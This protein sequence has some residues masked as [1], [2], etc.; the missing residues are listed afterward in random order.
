[1]ALIGR[2]A[3]GAAVGTALCTAIAQTLEAGAATPRTVPA[4]Q[5]LVEELSA[6]ARRARG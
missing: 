1:V 3:D 5:A 2:E 6:G 4:V